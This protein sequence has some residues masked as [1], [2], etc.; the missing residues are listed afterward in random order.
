MGSARSGCLGRSRPR[1][2]REVLVAAEVKKMLADTVPWRL[3]VRYGSNSSDGLLGS[4]G[5]KKAIWS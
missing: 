2:P 5:G 1:R 3:L 4:L